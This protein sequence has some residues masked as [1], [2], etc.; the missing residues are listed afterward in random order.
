[1][2]RLPSIVQFT[3]PGHEHGPD[4][5]GGNSKSWNSGDHRR[6]FM[7]A[8]GDYA[9]ANGRLVSDKELVFWGEWEPP[10]K[11]EALGKCPDK[12]HPRWLHSPYLP[13]AIPSPAQ[14]PGSCSSSSKRF[15]ACNP[16]CK[17][18]ESNSQNTKPFE[19]T[20]PFV[21]GDCFKYF[22]C[23]QRKAGRPTGMAKLEK[24][25]VILFGS[26]SGRAAKD[27]FFQL[28]TVFVV[29]SYLEYRPCDP[30]SLPQ[31]PSISPDYLKAVFRM[32]FPGPNPNISS[33]LKLRLYL[34]ATFASPENG[35]YSFAPAR[36]AGKTAEGFPRVALKDLPYLTNNLNSAPRFTETE[37]PAVLQFWQEIRDISRKHGCVEGVRFTYEK[38][39]K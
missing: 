26:T 4:S 1:M 37:E 2:D 35:M 30:A 17:A 38:R 20:D 18:D 32:A 39:S 33:D 11:V 10:S 14:L 36:V 24:G 25:S 16:G 31:H 3:H 22:V 28:D 19:N 7:M 23:K 12:F 15:K 5:T 6:K 9:A 8:E 34:G 13:S 21:F 27:A 29:G